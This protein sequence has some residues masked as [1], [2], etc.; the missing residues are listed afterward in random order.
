MPVLAMAGI[1]QRR[2]ASQPC[3]AGTE[4][5]VEHVSLWV[6]QVLHCVQRTPALWFAD[7]SL[8]VA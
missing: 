6:M 1:A 3:C 2:Q 8:T 5:H 4:P 7:M